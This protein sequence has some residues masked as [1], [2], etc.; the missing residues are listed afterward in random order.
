M[1]FTVLLSRSCN[2]EGS[3]KNSDAVTDSSPN[4]SDSRARPDDPVNSDEILDSK[5][6]IEHRNDIEI[7][8]PA[9][10]TPSSGSTNTSADDNPDTSNETR[11]QKK[12]QN[13]PS[14]PGNA[15]QGKGKYSPTGTSDPSNHK[16]PS[17][18][19]SDMTENRL[20]NANKL[21]HLD[22]Y[23]DNNGDD[24]NV[25][26]KPI[27]PKNPVK[28]GRKLD[29]SNPINPSVSMKPLNRRGRGRVLAGKKLLGPLLGAVTLISLKR[30][31]IS[32]K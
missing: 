1:A 29:S 24:K 2:T 26:T 32:L 5:D 8:T 27:S 19:S 22:K 20:K 28:T 15:K 23:S 7:P 21:N 30:N 16:S 6:N 13:N 12:P 3:E 18:R 17:S 10:A 31:L 9:A 25:N 4:S 11:H 14:N